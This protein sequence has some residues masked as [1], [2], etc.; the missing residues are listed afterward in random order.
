[1]RIQP[2]QY[3]AQLIKRGPWAGEHRAL[4][5]LTNDGS[6]DRGMGVTQHDGALAADKVDVFTTIRRPAACTAA[7]AET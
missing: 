7:V 2:Y 5:Q 1:V 4:F 6:S 3:V